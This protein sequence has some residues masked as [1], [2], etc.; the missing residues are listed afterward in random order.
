MDAGRRRV[1]CL[2]PKVIGAGSKP[3][4]PVAPI[5]IPY[6]IDIYA[7]K[8]AGAVGAQVYSRPK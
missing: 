2:A 3:I 8:G 6:K 5:A 4:C 1:G 7:R